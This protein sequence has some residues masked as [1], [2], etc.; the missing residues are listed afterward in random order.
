MVFNSGM[1]ELDRKVKTRAMKRSLRSYLINGVM[2]AFVKPR[3]KEQAM[4]AEEMREF[5]T[6]HFEPRAKFV[7]GVNMSEDVVD[8]IPVHW[9]KR[10]DHSSDSLLIYLHGGAFVME[11]PRIH[12][13]FLSHLVKACGMTALMPS[14]RL[15]PE[16]PFPAAVD[17][18]RK[19]YRWVLD[20]GFDPAKVIMAGDSAGGN[21]TL[22]TLQQAKAAGWDMPS[23]AILLSPGTDLSGTESQRSNIN[24]DPLFNE[25]AV[26]HVIK[27]YLGDDKSLAEDPR[28]SPMKGNFEGLPPLYFI[29]GSTE[30]FRDCSVLAAEKAEKAGVDT[31]CHIWSGMPHCFPLTF[32]DILPEAR[33]AIDDIVGFIEGHV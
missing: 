20:S 31:T 21:L 10:D 9:I 19:I 12:G 16:H 6:T 13:A 1:I 5:L 24:K 3:F 7:D 26:G 27:Y 32:A 15:A 23:C 25:H 30:I 33:Q 2:R 18:C 22:V 17:D 8:G 29:A 11:S 4:P 28:V 14:Y